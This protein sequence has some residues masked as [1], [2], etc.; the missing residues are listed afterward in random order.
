M[1]KLLEIVRRVD[2]LGR[3]V[4]PKTFREHLDLKP[5]DEVKIMIKGDSISITKHKTACLFCDTKSDILL[6]GDEPICAS[7]AKKIGQL[8]EER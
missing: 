6:F 2:E 3:I 8:K 4:L 7:C 5:Q 1:A